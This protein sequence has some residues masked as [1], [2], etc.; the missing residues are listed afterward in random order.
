MP[1]N[2]ARPLF[3]YARFLR[4]H[5][6]ITQAPKGYGVFA[7]F[8]RHGGRSDLDGDYVNNNYLFTFLI[9]LQ[10]LVDYNMA[11]LLVYARK[12]KTCS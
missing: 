4:E 2:A 11:I 5:S 1:Q 8:L 12:L 6:R 7:Y 3:K 9:L 10:N